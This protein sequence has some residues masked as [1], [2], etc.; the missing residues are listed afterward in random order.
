MD[1]ELHAYQI[2]AIVCFVMSRVQRQHLCKAA[3]PIRMH[4]GRE[5]SMQVKRMHGH[6]R[7]IRIRCETIFHGRDIMDG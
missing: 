7:G 3:F 2:I 4:R 5:V 1:D 6:D